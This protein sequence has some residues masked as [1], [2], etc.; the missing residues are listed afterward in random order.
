MRMAWIAAAALAVALTPG[1]KKTTPR[2]VD[3]SQA[4]DIPRSVAVEKLRELLPTCESMYCAAPS[5]TLK[6]SEVREWSVGDSELWFKDKGD[7]YRL[8]YAEITGVRLDGKGTK[9]FYAK[10]FTNRPTKEHMYFRWLTEEPAQQAVEL[11]EAVRPRN[12]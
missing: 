7:T 4:P 2:P 6:P 5:E 10:V 8:V 3:T 9:Y 11:L 12:P 1:C